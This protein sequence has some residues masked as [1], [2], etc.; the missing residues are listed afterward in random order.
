MQLA[1][2]GVQVAA[3]V[4]AR[5]DAA[6]VRLAAMADYPR[7]AHFAATFDDETRDEKFWFQRFGLWWD[8]NP[9]F[10]EGVP[11]GWILW[12]E[13]EIKGFLGNVPNE[14]LLN[15]KTVT[16]LSTTTWRVL[17]THR[18]HSLKLF[19]AA[20]RA[21]KG[22]IFFD[23]TPSPDAVAVVKGLKFELFPYNANPV[24]S[25]IVVNAKRVLQSR[26]LGAAAWLGAP[27]L[28][29]G[30]SVRLRLGGAAE[31]MSVRLLTQ[32]DASFDHL[33]Q[34]TK[35][36]YANTN[37]R[38]AAAINWQSFG[39]AASRKFLFGCYNGERLVGYLIATR[40]VRNELKVAACVDVWLDPEFSSALGNLLQFVR[41]WAGQEGIDVIEVP[42][43]DVPLGR[44]LGALGLFQRSF[45][46][47]Q[48]AYYKAPDVGA[49]D[50][51]ATYLSM[52]GDRGL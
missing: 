42:H 28:R 17:P 4:A 11:R 41:G 49:L 20:M 50:P 43:F 9:S 35:N 48:Q 34:R 38:S 26:G 6:Q 29:L 1:A 19:F 52:Q 23:T 37:V 24:K 39:T 32:A 13:G 40:G 25:F 22:S 5:A 21:A 10:R 46:G 31:R 14:F 15:G 16:A 12:D 7:L 30:Q 3:T 44:Q 8:E 2:G 51:A 47:E 33:W 18:N 36:R 27:A 45:S